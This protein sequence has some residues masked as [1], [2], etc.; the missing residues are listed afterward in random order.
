[1]LIV[2]IAVVGFFALLRGDALP[3]SLPIGAES[4]V[5]PIIMYHSL[6]KDPKLAG[7]YVL[8]PDDLER[9]MV[10]LSEHG[11]TPVLISELAAFVF[12][13]GDLPEKPV[14]ITLDDGYLNNSVYLPELLE[15][16]GFC[17]TISI[18]GEYAE[19]YTRYPDPS[20][21]YGYMT[22][23][24]IASLSAL[25]YIEIANHSF[26]VHGRLAV[27]YGGLSA[28]TLA[29]DAADMNEIMLQKLGFLPGTYA[30]PY[31]YTVK[32]SDRALAEL[33]FTATLGCGESVNTIRR[34]DSSCLL[35]LGRFNRPSGISTD[36]FMKHALGE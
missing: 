14:A 15:R 2:I 30:Y 36:S 5:V 12:E 22:W 4:R 28:Q 21:S 33:G 29:D 16:H 11:Y 26:F 27:K 10:Y 32:D 24:D 8:S 20:T 31:G 19:H 25:P 35:S 17:A 9:D 13:G 34:G 1:M 6:L 7:A 3:V 23:D 18:V